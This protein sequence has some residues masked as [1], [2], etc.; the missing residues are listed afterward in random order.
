[1]SGKL[2]C[3][4]CADINHTLIYSKDGFD[5]FRCGD[6]GSGFI[7]ASNFDPAT[8]YTREYFEGARGDGYA[9]YGASGPVL[10]REFAHI[11]KRI[12]KHYPAGGMLLEVGC[13]YGYFLQ[14]ARERWNVHGLEIS[15]DAV[16]KC[17]AAGLTLVRRG[18][19]SSETL[20]AFPAVDV[21]V[22]L[23]VIEHLE[24]PASVLAACFEKM[25]P[26]GVMYISTGDFG[27]WSARMMGRHWRLMTPPQHLS[28][29]TE[30][31]LTRMAAGVGAR[32]E[33]IYRPWKTV[34][35]SLIEF[36]LRRMLHLPN[37]PRLPSV[38]SRLGI[39]VNLFDTM[40]VVMRK[41]C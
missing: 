28:Y 38:A 13:A 2:A 15:A 33:A 8:Y 10:R 9:D 18:P 7:D 19:A 1:M 32:V 16:S 11:A 6:C 34:P 14:V 12:E 35:L 22:M 29:F 25:A 41:R 31:G 3:P 23:D 5:V 20:A 39:P 17:H 4:A 21:V 37:W 26:G 36:Q 30:V 40:H 24:D 27:A